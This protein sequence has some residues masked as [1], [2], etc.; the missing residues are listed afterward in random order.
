MPLALMGATVAVE[1]T[2]STST[3]RPSC[4]GSSFG[5]SCGPQALEGDAVFASL[6]D[7][8]DLGI[9]A[10]CPSPSIGSCR[11]D[12]TRPGANCHCPRGL[13]LRAGRNS[14]PLPM[15]K[16]PFG[17][18]E[19]VP[20]RIGRRPRGARLQVLKRSKGL[21]CSLP[22]PSWRSTRTAGGHPCSVPAIRAGARPTRDGVSPKLPFTHRSP[23]AVHNRG[24]SAE[25]GHPADCVSG[26]CKRC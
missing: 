7:R 4:H 26:D 23:W 19:R 2:A 15:R 1:R 11:T 13:P 25:G 17:E 3:A 12:R 5:P 22:T 10:V 8:P 18:R 20:G 24:L 16:R 21:R 14:R 6:P 9:G